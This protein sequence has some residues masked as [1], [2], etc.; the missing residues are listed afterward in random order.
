MSVSLYFT[1]HPSRIGKLILVASSR[2]LQR[3]GLLAEGEHSESWLT[4]YYGDAA[5]S[6]LELR[7][8][9]TTTLEA[10]DSFLTDGAELSLPFDLTG[11]TPLQRMVWL[12]IA[13][14]PYGST[15]SYTD[16]ATN[17][18]FPRAV[19]AVAS[20]CGANPIPL[21]IACHRVIARDGTLGGFSLGGLEV[22]EQ[23][24]ALEKP[25]T[26]WAA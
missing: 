15:I 13:K 19:R 14:I 9:F 23:L 8:F 5:S 20:A 26:L 1:T 16:L 17:V 6:V 12:A 25:K 21:A 22:K 3:I 7:G 2:G 24:L 18:G 4:R 10:I 11:G